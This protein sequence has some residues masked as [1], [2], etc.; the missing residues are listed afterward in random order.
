[1]PFHKTEQTFSNMLVSTTVPGMLQRRRQRLS[2]PR[3]ERQRAML[4][5]ASLRPKLP[6][7]ASFF[8]C[9]AI[10]LV[11][12]LTPVLAAGMC[13]TVSRRTFDIYNTNHWRRVLISFI[14]VSSGR[15]DIRRLPRAVRATDS[16]I[17]SAHVQATVRWQAASSPATAPSLP[18]P[19]PERPCSSTPMSQ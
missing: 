4:I 11:A 18:A 9:F 7:R 10:F 17:V 19:S 6:F 12:P 3:R 5:S 15:L 13:R 8:Y 14:F 2:L 1:M 16:T